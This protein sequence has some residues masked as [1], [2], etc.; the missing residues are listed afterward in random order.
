MSELEQAPFASVRTKLSQPWKAGVGNAEPRKSGR[1]PGI[2]QGVGA[3]A[4][5]FRLVAGM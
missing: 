5:V 3:Q 2:F 1:L 4:D